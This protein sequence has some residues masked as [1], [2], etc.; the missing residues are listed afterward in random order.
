M[1]CNLATARNIASREH[2]LE[3]VT[4]FRSPH[5]RAIRPRGQRHLGA[6]RRDDEIDKSD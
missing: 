6:A 3:P 4:L 1:S 5:H 2:V